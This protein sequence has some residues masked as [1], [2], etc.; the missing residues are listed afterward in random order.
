MYNEVIYNGIKLV[1]EK[2]RYYQV[3]T[4]KINS[5]VEDSD[6]SILTLTYQD[7][8]TSDTIAK[9]LGLECVEDMEMN[10]TLGYPKKFEKIYFTLN[11]LRFQKLTA[12][13]HT[14]NIVIVDDI[15]SR[16]VQTYGYT[17]IVVSKRDYR[18]PD[19]INFLFSGN[20]FLFIRR[21]GKI[22]R[23]WTIKDFPKL[24]IGDDSNDFT[25]ESETIYTL[26]KRYN[27]YT[28][29]EVDYQDQFILEI[30]RILKDY[31]IELVRWNKETPLTKLS[32]VTY[33]FN[34][35]PVN[36]IHPRRDFIDKHIL[37]KKQPIDFTLH[38]PDMVLFHD[39]KNKYENVNLLT[40]FCSFKTSDR[41]GDRWTAAVK[42][43]LITE[44][45]NHQY[46]PDDN[47]NFAYQC[48][49]RCEL[50]FYEVFDDRYN[51]L[52]EISLQLDS[53]DKDG[54]GKISEYSTHK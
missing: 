47:S 20:K 4:G 21:I 54:S 16:V 41:Y 51:F 39:F 43:G 52:E 29:R 50:Y 14:I 32:Y 10:P 1:T 48:Q 23:G 24:I 45:F 31:G 18:N 3:K 30:R 9:S 44:D 25:S 13:N 17:T 27:D 26:R 42:W 8:S 46:N 28:I 12:D 33:Q 5:I 49:F 38:T 40:N 53:A 2:C 37:P 6:S 34:Q 35:T 19:F 22:P 11:G 36:D 15:D 7:G